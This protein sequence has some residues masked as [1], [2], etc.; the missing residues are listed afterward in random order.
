[1]IKNSFFANNSTAGIEADGGST[2]AVSNSQITFNSIGIAAGGAV[3][4][5]NSD[6]NSNTTAISGPTQSYGNNR[7]V[8][9][10]TKGTAPTIISGE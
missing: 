1:M 7:L 10:S 4:L 6:I 8:G 3:T 5:S 2:I 9:N